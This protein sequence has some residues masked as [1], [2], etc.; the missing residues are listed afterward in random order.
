M[1]RDGS[2]TRRE[3]K[4]EKELEKAEG[5]GSWAAGEERQGIEWAPPVL[6]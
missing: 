1:C 5:R 3:G 4:K 2:R 6:L